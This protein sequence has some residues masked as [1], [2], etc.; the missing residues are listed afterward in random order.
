MQRWVRL[1]SYLLLIITCLTVS[2]S[3]S[4]LHIILSDPR[5]SYVDIVHFSL[6]HN[7]II[8]V[9][10]T[11][12]ASSAAAAPLVTLP[13]LIATSEWR[14][15]AAL[16]DFSTLTEDLSSISSSNSASERCI[17]L[18]TDSSLVELSKRLYLY[19]FWE[20]SIASSNAWFA[21]CPIG[22]RER[23]LRLS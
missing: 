19:S 21:P 16:A 12:A 20:S 1:P 15:L 2:R 3:N 7:K 9:Q 22:N 11:L 13:L 6:Q 4:P 17:L 18:L 5:T 23:R 8:L 10:S 14:N